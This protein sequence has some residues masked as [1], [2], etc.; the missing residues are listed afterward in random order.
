MTTRLLCTQA[1]LSTRRVRRTARAPLRPRPCARARRASAL[2]AA[3]AA[4][5]HPAADNARPL[6]AALARP[7]AFEY[8]DKL[9]RQFA[10]APKVYERFLE[11]RRQAARAAPFA[12]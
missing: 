6:S 11:V 5:M 9:R 8:L 3:P 7:Q 4:A 10:H 12:R 2:G 1:I